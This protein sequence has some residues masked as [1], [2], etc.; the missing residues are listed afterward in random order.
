MTVIPRWNVTRDSVA[1]ILMS[2]LVVGLATIGVA[3]K[4]IS[5]VTDIVDRTASL[6]VELIS[7]LTYHLQQFPIQ[8]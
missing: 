3:S 7:V 6:A 1:V 8:E 5:L 4:P 2:I